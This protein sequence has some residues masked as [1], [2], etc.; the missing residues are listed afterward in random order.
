MT[1]RIGANQDL[2]KKY[3]SGIPHS[4]VGEYT[5]KIKCPCHYEFWRHIEDIFGDVKDKTIADMGCGPGLKGL[6]LAM[7][8]ANVIGI[9]KSNERLDECKKNLALVENLNGKLNVSFYKHDLEKEISFLTSC[10]ADF[11]LCYEVIEH[12][13]N[14]EVFVQEIAR[15]IKP[16]GWALIT[17]PNKNVCP[18]AKGEKVYGERLHGH[19]DAFD[20]ASLK[21]IFTIDGILVEDIFFYKHS[22][23]RVCCSLIHRFMK[24]DKYRDSL[25]VFVCNLYNQVIF[26]VLNL[27][28]R[29]EERLKREKD[30][31]KAIFI[32]IRKA[33]K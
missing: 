7:A 14:V 10:C 32:V 25:P 8:K 30:A 21:D 22:L 4:R 20:A 11:I 9:D 29:F 31:G 33:F 26:P 28:V 17:T 1:N 27:F 24:F 23:M 2:G 19:V 15:I 5:G 3:F 16:G 18:V 13:S 12:L 6:T